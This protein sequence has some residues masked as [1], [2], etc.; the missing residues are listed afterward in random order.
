[1]HKACDCNCV[2]H[3]QKK[4]TYFG[5]RKSD[6]TARGLPTGGSGGNRAER[7]EKMIQDDYGKNFET[8][9]GMVLHNGCKGL[10][11]FVFHQRLFHLGVQPLPV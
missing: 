1:M 4:L 10:S 9:S 6:A 5:W 3:T 7:A 2:P 8:R 11:A